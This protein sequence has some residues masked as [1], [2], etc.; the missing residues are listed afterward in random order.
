M[1]N[2]LKIFL[3]VALFVVGI[4]AV[5]AMN[6]QDTKT[7]NF[8]NQEKIQLTHY[9]TVSASGTTSKIYKDSND[10]QYIYNSN[11]NLVGYLKER[12]IT[13][14]NNEMLK[15]TINKIS[16]DSIVNSFST[17]NDLKSKIN[18][19]VKSIINTEKTSFDK[20]ELTKID[21]VESYNEINFVYT[22]HIDGY[23]VN[24][25]ITVSVDLNGEV[26]SFVA[27]RQGMF[28]NL[29]EININETELNDYIL[30][31]IEK[32]FKYADYEIFSQLI[33]NVDGK[34]VLANY[35]KIVLEDG[36]STSTIV[37][38]EI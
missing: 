12:T 14:E 30:A 19:F 23:K 4:S 18:E 16:S 13:K 26:V 25:S 5:G 7:V 33:D 27:N 38:Y 20:Y 6:K 8:L 37:Y 36:T 34:I 29:T 22:K 17:N 35:I 9:K 24:D 28:D 15:L 2:K 3:L 31:E 32:E 10:N 11:N 1:K 21:Y